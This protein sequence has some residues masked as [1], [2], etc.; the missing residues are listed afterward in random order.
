MATTTTATVATAATAATTTTTIKHKCI[1]CGGDYTHNK[2]AKSKSEGKGAKSTSTSTSSASASASASGDSDNYNKPRPNRLC[3][4]CHHLRNDYY[5]SHYEQYDKIPKCIGTYGTYGTYGTIDRTASRFPSCTNPVNKRLIPTSPIDWRYY[6]K[7]K[8]QE[9]D[10][11]SEIYHSLCPTHYQSQRAER[12]RLSRLIQEQKKQE[13]QEY[14]QSEYQ[15]WQ[16]EYQQELSTL[17]LVCCA[18]YK[19]MKSSSDNN[20]YYS[21]NQ[22]TRYNAS[23]NKGEP[24]C[25][26]CQ[27]LNLLL[28]SPGASWSKCCGYKTMFGRCNG[29]TKWKYEREYDR[30]DRYHHHQQRHQHQRQGRLIG[31]R[32]CL[33]CMRCRE[34]DLHS[35]RQLVQQILQEDDDKKEKE[36]E[37]HSTSSTTSATIRAVTT[38]GISTFHRRHCPHRHELVLL[39]QQKGEYEYCRKCATDWNEPVRITPLNPYL[40]PQDQLFFLYDPDYGIYATGTLKQR[41]I[42]IDHFHYYE[43]DHPFDLS[44]H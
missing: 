2:A 6:T 4:S 25:Y 12:K 1:S 44:L 42:D 9:D 35:R 36:K 24:L 32:L 26:H 29:I 28:P 3:H 34:L 20:D 16:Q 11:T 5:Y 43:D 10:I 7:G 37:K 41:M 17:P 8:G 39:S 38:K 18:H 19:E 31:S 13:A 23:T 27:H 30:D 14:Q 15:Q 33:E 22:K 21:C 40:V